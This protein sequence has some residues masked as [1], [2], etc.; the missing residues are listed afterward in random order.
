MKKTVA[1][2]L[3]FCM[4]LPLAACGGSKNQT[5]SPAEEKKTA[6]VLSL[7]KSLQNNYEWEDDTLLVQSEYSYVTLREAESENYP[8]LAE[9]VNQLSAM[10]KRSMEDEFDNFCSMAREELSYGAIDPYV[11]T[12]DVQVRRADSIVVS[13]LSD[14]YSDYGMID[15]RAV[16][17]FRL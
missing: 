8:E 2:L 9:T 6:E 12:L 5:E 14:S 16:D 3:A 11:S 13:L 15:R 17:N 10:Q 7:Q 4:A 1:F